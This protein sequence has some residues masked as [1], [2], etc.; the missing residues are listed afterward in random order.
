MQSGIWQAAPGATVGPLT[1]NFETGIGAF[2]ILDYWCV[3]LRVTDGSAPGTY[4]SNTGGATDPQWFKEC[5]LE[6]KDA[7]QTL[8]FSVNTTTFNINE[9]SGACV[10]SMSLLYAQSSPTP[11][12]N[13]FVVMLE[14][15]SFDN[16]LAMSGIPGITAA[17][18]NNSNS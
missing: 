16:I 18:T 12:T 6:S 17:T 4:I 7:G 13:V 8:T 9:D 10:R 14:N 3:I 1:V 5:Q 2:G 11:I 15:H